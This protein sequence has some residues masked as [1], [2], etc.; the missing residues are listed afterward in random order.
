MTQEQ[1]QMLLGQLQGNAQLQQQLKALGSAEATTV[2]DLV[3]QAGFSL[4][5]DGPGGMK[6]NGDELEVM[7]GG[8]PMTTSLG[9]PCSYR[10]NE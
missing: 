5:I 3:Q 8:A 9:L 6:L 7:A 10:C 2:V 1:L 4:P